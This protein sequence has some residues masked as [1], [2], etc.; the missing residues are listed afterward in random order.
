MV[1]ASEEQ[2]EHIPIVIRTLNILKG[3]GNSLLDLRA[4]VKTEMTA[5]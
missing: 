5:V 3:I 1:N 2:I 4:E